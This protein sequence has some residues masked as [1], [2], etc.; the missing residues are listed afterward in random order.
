MRNWR[1]RNL[2]A[3]ASLAIVSTGFVAPAHATEPVIQDESWQTVA[4]ATAASTIELS[5]EVAD[6]DLR[7]IVIRDKNGEPATSVIAVSSKSELESTLNHLATDSN[8]VSIEVDKKIDFLGD[9]VATVT[10]PS[11]TPSYEQWNYTNLRM[12]EVNPFLTGA[13]ITVAVIDT[14]VNRTGTDLDRIGQVLDGC[15]WVTSPTNVCRGTGVTDE[16]GHGTHVAGIIA[17]QNDGEGITGIAPEATILPLRVL[18]ASGSGYIS[19]IPAAID[20]AVSHGADVINMYLGGT[21]DYFLI[22]NAVNNAVAAGVVVIAAGGNDGPTNTKPSYP[23]AYENSIA[24]AATDSTGTV[25]EY[26]NQG[27]YLDIAAPGSAIVS[28]WGTRY[29][30]LSGTSMAAPHVSALAAL[31]LQ[32]GIRASSIKTRM[33]QTADATAPRNN[34]LRYGAGLINPYSALRCNPTNCTEVITAPVVAETVS[35]PISTEPVVVAIAPSIKKSLAIKVKSGRKIYVTV[36]APK[37]STTWIQRKSGT[38][39]KTI[40]KAKSKQAATFKV[41]RSGTY[42]VKISSSTETVISKNFR[43]K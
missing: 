18:D 34:Q 1:S 41:G 38:K 33:Q 35:D 31:M 11:A 23:A 39:W 26:S 24:V 12:P 20:Y 40:A 22:E 2:V 7:M 37:N 25:A 27:N 13:G 32:S 19:D 28:I 42:R 17:A 16:N 14:G 9:V 4:Q 10:S 3:L 29:A 5:A 6:G 15:D 30:A 36:T 8:V 43:I 21:Y